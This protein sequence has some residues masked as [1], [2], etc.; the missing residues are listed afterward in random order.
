MFVI[1]HNQLRKFR[2]LGYFS[3]TIT[4]LFLSLLVWMYRSNMTFQF[5]SQDYQVEPTPPGPTETLFTHAAPQ[6]LNASVVAVEGTKTLLLGAFLEHRTYKKTVR[7]NAVVLRKERVAYRCLFRCQ[8]QL[9][10][11]GSFCSIH[12]DHFGFPY[13]TAD[14]LCHLPSGCQSPSHVAVTTAAAKSKGAP[15]ED[16][17]EVK[18]QKKRSDSFPYNFT[19]C[20]STMYNFTNVLQLIQSLEMLQLLG[21]NRVVIYKTST[22]PETQR[23]LDYYTQ[24]GFVEVLAWSALSRFLNVSRVSKPSRGPGDLHYF[25]Q[26]PALNDCVYRYMYQSR[27]VALHDTDELIVPQSVYSWSELLPLLEKKYGLDKCY[28]FDNTVFRSTITLPPPTN[29]TLLPPSCCPGWQNVS[30]VNILAHLYREPVRKTHS[31]TKVIVNPRAVFSMSVHTALKSQRGC[32]LVN[33]TIALMYHTR[34]P[35]QSELTLDQLI[36]DDRL[37]N[38]SSLLI[39]NVNTV[40]RENGLLPEESVQDPLFASVYVQVC[41][42]VILCLCVCTCVYLC[43]C[44]R[45][46]GRLFVP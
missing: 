38:Y 32:A 25:G 4:I 24:K 13:G 22:S 45:E 2:Q 37:L 15:D 12:D 8:G 10:T 39:P 27:Y 3:P 42:F 35:Q 7:V 30:G 34:P 41:M 14:I 46:K 1:S 29:Q 5:V 36:Y 6:E 11:S 17:L 18:N 28:L 19:V 20:F 43:V 31:N 33:G 9:H 44:V 26:I 40:I 16:F 23:I 21:A